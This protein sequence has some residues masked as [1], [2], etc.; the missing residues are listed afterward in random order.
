MFRVKAHPLEEIKEAVPTEET[1]LDQIHRCGEPRVAL[2]F[3]RMFI[4]L[5][6]NFDLMEVRDVARGTDAGEKLFLSL[7]NLKTDFPTHECG[8]KTVV[9]TGIKECKGVDFLLSMQKPDGK[10]GSENASSLR[11]GLGGLGE[12]FRVRKLKSPAHKKWLE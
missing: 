7:L 11:Q 3:K 1:E 8:K 9:R 5:K 2:K 10:H 12:D 6:G 4:Q